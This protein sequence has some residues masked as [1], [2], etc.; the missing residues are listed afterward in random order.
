MMNEM[1]K[2]SLNTLQLGESPQKTSLFTQAL[3]DLEAS[4]YMRK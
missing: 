4:V 2:N 3:K 1:G